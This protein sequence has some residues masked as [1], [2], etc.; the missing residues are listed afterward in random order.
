MADRRSP[1]DHSSHEESEA[2]SGMGR[3]R[4][5]IGYHTQVS[6]RPGGVPGCALRCQ[7]PRCSAGE[8]GEGQEGRR[9]GG[10]GGGPLRRRTARS[11]GF[12]GGLLACLLVG[13]GL[14]S[15]SGQKVKNTLEGKDTF[16][17][18]ATPL[19]WRMWSTMPNTGDPYQDKRLLEGAMMHAVLMRNI[20]AFKAVTNYTVVDVNAG[21]ENGRS[22]WHLAAIHGWGGDRKPSA[23]LN[24]TVV[25]EVFDASAV[26]SAWTVALWKETFLGNMWDWC[27]LKKKAPSMV[28]RDKSLQTP[29]HEAALNGNLRTLKL[30]QDLD[31]LVP[32]VAETSI[33]GVVRAAPLKNEW[34]FSWTMMNWGALNVRTNVRYASMNA[35]ING[36]VLTNAA[37]KAATLGMTVLDYASIHGHVDIVRYL[38]NQPPGTVGVSA[39]VTATS[40]WK[41]RAYQKA[42][43][44]GHTDVVHEFVKKLGCAAVLA[45]TSTGG[46]NILHNAAG[47]GHYFLLLNFSLGCRATPAGAAA[48]ETAFRATTISDPGRFLWAGDTACSMA[49]VQV[50]YIKTQCPDA[51]ACFPGNHRHACSHDDQVACV[52][53][54]ECEVYDHESV[55]V[56]NKH[57]SFSQDDLIQHWGFCR[58]ACR[59]TLTKS[60]C[61]A[62]WPGCDRNFQGQFAA[63]S[64]LPENNDGLPNAWYADT[65]IFSDPYVSTCTPLT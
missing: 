42:A 35:N 49:T 34:G 32:S 4:V 64:D 37:N 27:I 52:R 61:G 48:L 7:E 24:G 38:L 1:L 56:L 44:I 5:S 30:I 53:D 26:G 58:H 46:E 9:T 28:A 3:E 59:N 10:D 65:Q 43:T 63:E 15:V 20:E 16:S 21:D 50:A 60:G 33:G 57:P 14:A 40:N 11:R 2:P 36:G 13:A 8:S 22:V 12:G 19:D 55:C 54:D 23:E 39:L 62:S 6:T 29:A 41:E 25:R 18:D 45:H 51:G 31:G 17:L 47:G